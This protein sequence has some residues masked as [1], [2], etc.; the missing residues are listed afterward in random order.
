MPTRIEE[1][2]ASAGGEV[3]SQVT[4]GMPLPCTQP[5]VYVVALSGS[6]NQCVCYDEAP[7]SEEAVRQWID[8]V[9][10]LTLD[11]EK[12]T[13]AGL[14]ARLKRFWLPDETI[15]YIGKAGTSLRRRVN[16]YY[17]TALGAAG[18]HA[19]GHWIKTLSVLDK[20][21]IYWRATDR[22]G[23]SALEKRFLHVF[24]QNV[25]DESRRKLLDPES[26]LPFANLQ[27][28]GGRRRQHGLGHQVIR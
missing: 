28:P 20:L 14:T 18:P 22:E 19:G 8:R 4:W 26:C 13:V 27:C 6:N 11:G 16:Q 2:F 5:G 25:S 24:G 12:P 10:N 23:A 1:L 21:S 3:L 9:P 15:V 7:I 17:C